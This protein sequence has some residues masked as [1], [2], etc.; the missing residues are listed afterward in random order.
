MGD[1]MEQEQ[2]IARPSV[3]DAF[4]NAILKL[5]IDICSNSIEYRETFLTNSIDPEQRRTLINNLIELWLQLIPKVVGWKDLENK[6][7]QN[8]AE[9]ME[10][11]EKYFTNPAL[12][13]D[14][15]AG[16]EL[17][18]FQKDLRFCIE[19]LGVTSFEKVE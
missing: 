9:K 6:R 5:W 16:I 8:L 17:L 19:S 18:E 13:L 4:K 3:S 7:L 12:L 10:E 1:K 11:Y 2:R 14:P 15:D